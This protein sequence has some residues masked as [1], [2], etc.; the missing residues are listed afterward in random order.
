MGTGNGL[1]YVIGCKAG[2][3]DDNNSDQDDTKKKKSVLSRMNFMSWMKRHGKVERARLTMQ[4]LKTVGDTIQKA[5]R[6]SQSQ[7]ED[8]DLRETL[9]G[10][11]SI[12][13]MPLMEVTHPRDNDDEDDDAIEDEMKGDLCFFAVSYKT[14]YYTL[15]GQ[16]DIIAIMYMLTSYALL[17]TG[18]WI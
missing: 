3:K 11:C 1:G 2:N 17:Y 9:S 18:C 16:T 4:K 8:V 12:V 15:S 6:S 7:K 5:E 14:A 13:Q 10:T